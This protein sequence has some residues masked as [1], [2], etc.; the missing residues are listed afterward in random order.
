MT[1]G[2][3]HKKG[4]D[5]RR[6]Q[7]IKT[8]ATFASVA[9]VAGSTALGAASTEAK[10]DSKAER[11]RPG[12]DYEVIVIGGGNAGAVAARDCMKHGYKTL[13]I[14]AGD[15]LGGRTFT[16]DF[17]GT[18]IELGGTWVYNN[19]PFVWSEIERYGL[20]IEET[21]GAV[22]D[23][24]YLR[25][26]D[27]QRLAFTE[28]QLIEAMSGWEL[29]AGSAREVV[30]RPYDLLYNRKAVLAAD[31]VNALEHLQ[32]LELTPLQYAFNR[33]FIELMANNEASAISYAEI[34]RYYALGSAYFPT[35]MDALARFK[36]R[37]GT[38]NLI[39][40]MIE[41]GAPEVRMMTPVKSVADQGDKVLVTTT[42]HEELTC[43]AVISCLP[44]N[45][46][47]DVAFSPPLPTGVIAAGRERHVGQ[48]IKVYIKVEGDIGNV[49][50]V[51][52]GQPLN[53]AMTYKQA[54][55]YTVLVA[56]GSSPGN[57]D[58]QAMQKALSVL[59]PGVKMLKHLAYD[60]NSEPYSK[61][62]WASYRPH[63]IE[64][65]YDQ[66]Q[67]AQGR[68]FFGSGDHGEGWRGTIDGAIGAGIRAARQVRNHLG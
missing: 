29:F 49:A 50:A 6:R 56:F 27:G 53:Y 31:Q 20:A 66:F 42:A 32:G 33:G 26:E 58:G 28:T 5:V 11:P 62:T 43:E 1:K 65:Y 7:F 34:L 60:W 59:L 14:E 63:W 41:D 23:V 16:T 68:I 36:L 15:R 25:M 21:P 61:G 3:G 38:V 39:N 18:P 44:M 67:K 13:L 9:A 10:T 46:L 12:Y 45:V 47:V 64:R 55:D 4:N 35:F 48:G 22:P 37:D 8:T 54:E 2:S 52:P 17:H 30:P 51:A 24:M 40:H 57:L 19:Q